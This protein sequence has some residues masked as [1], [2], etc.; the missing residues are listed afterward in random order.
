MKTLNVWA[1]VV[2]YHP[3][4]DQLSVLIKNLL[5]Q[6]VKVVICDN[7]EPS[8]VSDWEYPSVEVLPIGRNVGIAEAQNIGMSRAFKSGADAVLQLDQDSLPSE[9]MIAKLVSAFE[10]LVSSGRNVGL[11]GANIIDANE[12]FK[13]GTG[14]KSHRDKF[15]SDEYFR[16]DSIVSSGTLIPV[17]VYLE[18]GGMDRDLFIDLVDYEYCCRVK[19]RDFEVYQATHALLFHAIGEG[20]K[21]IFL[22]VNVGNHRPFRDYYQFRNVVLL[23]WRRYIPLQW[24]LG[25]LL[26]LVIRLFYYITLGKSK[27]DHLCYALKGVRH[28]MKK[29]SG[30]CDE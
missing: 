7:S 9:D 30:K 26:R 15:A 11:V 10:A 27:K 17:N 14:K 25:N 5:N 3:S 18:C 16:V 13:M 24:K 4:L 29:K 1:I 12:R 21:K 20:P 2:T 28:G 6:S 8:I 22:G 19:S 23:L